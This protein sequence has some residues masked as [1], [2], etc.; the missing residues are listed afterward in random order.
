M[1]KSGSTIMPESFKTR[2]KFLSKLAPLL[3]VVLGLGMLPSFQALSENLSQQFPSFSRYAGPINFLKI[4]WPLMVVYIGLQWKRIPVDTRRWLPVIFG[5]GTIATLISANGCHFPPLFLR[6]WF[7]I[8]VGSICGI[9]LLLLPRKYSKITVALWGVIVLSGVAINLFFPQL[10]N[11]LFRNIFDFTYQVPESRGAPI[12]LSG[13]YDIASL[14]KL[15]AWLPW[16]FG[17]FF[18]DSSSTRRNWA[19]FFSLLVSCTVLIPVTT[20]RG[21]VLGMALGWILFT[22]HL[23]FQMRKK[24]LLKW[25]PVAVISVLIL[26]WVAIPKNVLETRFLAY[27]GVAGTDQQAVI[28]SRVSSD[29]RKRIWKL[30][31]DRISTHP[32]GLACPPKE[33]YEKAGIEAAYHSHNIFLEQ[34]SSRG[35]IWGTLHMLLWLCA[36]IW[37]WRDKTLQGTMLT[38]AVVTTLGLGMVDHPWFVLNHAMIMAMFLFYY[39]IR[40]TNQNEFDPI[41]QSM[42]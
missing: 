13:F 20:Q 34:Y 1:S 9:T 23:I 24:W 16:A 2:E 3:A 27:F 28:Q 36:L 11:W 25:V 41:G 4:F 7:V 15:L 30:A 21:P 19:V 33:D 8:C 26:G 22:A 37:A 5:I 35:W 38:G 14:G 17:I 40:P 31:V 32:M 42:M 18:I 39:W 6:E 10:T 12:R 29:Q